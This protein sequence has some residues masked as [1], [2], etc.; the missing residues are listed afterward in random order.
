[1]SLG[2]T[3]LSCCAKIKIITIIIEQTMS[4]GS[5]RDFSDLIPDHVRSKPTIRRRVG[6]GIEIGHNAGYLEGYEAGKMKGL[7][8]GNE[9]GYV[10]G[11]QIATK[12]KS[13]LIALVAAVVG[14]CFGLGIAIYLGVGFDSPDKLAAAAG[15]GCACTAGAAGWFT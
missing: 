2:K 7:E 8:E 4:E 3:A 5:R 14:G 9:E 1:L 6:E 11:I 13:V 10:K 12:R 15:I